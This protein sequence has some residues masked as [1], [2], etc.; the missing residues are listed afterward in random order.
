[1]RSKSID[2]IRDSRRSTTGVRN[3]NQDLRERLHAMRSV[4]PILPQSWQLESRPAHARSQSQRTPHRRR[5][6]GNPAAEIRNY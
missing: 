5:T 2:A 6:F 3:A 4:Y 1:M